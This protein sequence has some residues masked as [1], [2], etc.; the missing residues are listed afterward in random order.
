MLDRRI[1]FRHVE[2]FATIER[3]GSLKAACAALNLSQPALSKTLKELEDIL[4]AR[5]MERDRGGVRLTPEGE[6]FLEFAGLS[7]AALRRGVDG[8]AA[9]RAGEG[10]ILR[11]GALPSVAARLMPP[12]VALFRRLSPD[13]RLDLQDGAHGQLTV[14]LRAGELDIVVGRLG[15]PAVMQ[16]VS[17]TQLYQERVVC[18][19]RPGHP[20]GGA[21][22]DPAALIRW[23]VLYPPDGAAIRPLL[24]RWCLAQGLPAFPDRIACVSGA[25]GRNYVA[26]SDALWFISEGVVAQD[27]AEGRLVALPLDLGLTAGPVGLMT[28]PGT[29]ETASQR[30]FARA[31]ERAVSEL[32][33]S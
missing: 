18:V 24:D 23:P 15:A 2:C 12:A 22:T 16:G 14:R 33:I 25:F 1:K 29:T 32:P 10:D 4:G 19:T 7:L 17:F 3:L 20:L 6:V 5:L 31:L 11:V 9:L 28:R 8:V 27:L 13:T 30:L 26:A 21:T